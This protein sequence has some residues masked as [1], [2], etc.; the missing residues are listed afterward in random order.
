MSHKID[1][2]KH[3]LQWTFPGSSLNLKAEFNE[4]SEAMS[5]W[6]CSLLN[7]TYFVSWLTTEWNFLISQQ[8]KTQNFCFPFIAICYCSFARP[9]VSFWTLSLLYFHWKLIE[10]HAGS[11]YLSLFQALFY[12]SALTTRSWN[13]TFQYYWY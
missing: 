3:S 12:L 10:R 13:V 1:P 7:S 5:K 4:N 2:I 6:N 8:K 11:A 9:L